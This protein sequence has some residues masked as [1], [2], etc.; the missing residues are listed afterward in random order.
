MSSQQPNQSTQSNRPNQ[1]SH[2]NK[3]LNQR[4]GTLI[5]TPPKISNIQPRPLTWVEEAAY[6]SL[7]GETPEIKQ[8]AK[9]ILDLEVD[10]E[11]LADSESRKNKTGN[12]LNKSK[13]QRIKDLLEWATWEAKHI[14]SLPEGK[15]LDDSDGFGLIAF[16]CQNPD[17]R[18]PK[19][20]VTREL[21]EE[22]YAGQTLCLS[23][24]DAK[25]RSTNN[26][27]VAKAS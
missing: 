26:Q 6:W 5:I 23:C 9:A 14:S 8:E 3:T 17:C 1:S 10:K 7:Y 12:G 16:R 18:R 22:Y 20:R 11:I 15:R 21:F 25:E 4:I 19:V 2:A 13:E 27:G 24:R